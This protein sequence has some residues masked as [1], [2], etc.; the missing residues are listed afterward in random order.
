MEHAGT[1]GEFKY[2]T[3]TI[4][5]KKHNVMSRHYYVRD[6]QADVTLAK[7]LAHTIFGEAV[8]WPAREEAEAIVNEKISLRATIS[9]LG[10]GWR[11]ATHGGFCFEARAPV[12]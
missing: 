5:A 8:K 11:A 6:E 9:A 4:G 3:E 10:E 2:V 12:Q 7:F 1:A